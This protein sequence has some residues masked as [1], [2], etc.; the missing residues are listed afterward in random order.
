MTHAPFTGSAA[1]A[2]GSL[3]P[4]RAVIFDWDNTLVETWPA[5]HEALTRTF[6]EF[7]LVPWTFEETKQRVRKSMRES[8]PPLFGDRWEEAGVFFK[9]AFTDI[10]LDR[11]VPA[12]GAAEMLADLVEAGIYLGV[13]SNKNGDTLRVEAAHLEWDRFFGRIVGAFDAKRDKPAVDPVHL[14]LRDSGIGCGADVWFA[15]DTD[16]DLECATHAGC[17]PVLVRSDPP[18]NGEFDECQP[19]LYFKNCLA[20]SNLIRRL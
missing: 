2:A 11:L 16:I 20:L 13:V 1:G 15:G 14:A 4:P 8:F 12:P 18:S 19:A 9:Q 5:I 6:T 3:S 17:L 7:G 10:H